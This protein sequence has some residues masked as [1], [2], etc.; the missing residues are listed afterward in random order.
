MQTYWPLFWPNSSKV[1]HSAP[2]VRLDALLPVVG[3]VT[4]AYFERHER[5][6]IDETVRLI[7]CPSVSDLNGWSEQPSEIAFSHVLQARVVALD[8]APESTINAAH[9]GLRGHMLEVLSLERLLPAL[10]GWANGTGAW[11]LPQAAAGDGSLQLWAEL[12]W[13]GRAEVAGYIYLV[14]NTRA[15]SHLE[16]ILERDGDN[17]VGL[18]HVQRNPAGT[19]FDFGATYSTELERCLLERVLNSAQPL[20]D[21]HPLYL[22]E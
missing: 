15:E 7:W 21:T 17:L 6:Q 10:R 4:L 5:I 2:Q 1:D 18:F 16:L 9:F 3:T 13:C 11:S 19:F 12:N 20:C 8:A 14:G 22:L